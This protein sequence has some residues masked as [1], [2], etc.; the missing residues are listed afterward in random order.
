[1]KKIKKYKIT[2]FKKKQNFNIITVYGVYGESQI[3]I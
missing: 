1:M 3:S 2:N